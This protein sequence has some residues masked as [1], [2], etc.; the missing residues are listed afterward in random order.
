MHSSVISV[1]HGSLRVQRKP[2]LSKCA[3]WLPCARITKYCVVVAPP[4]P[5]K[6]SFCKRKLLQLWR[7]T[8]NL[9]ILVGLFKKKL[10]IITLFSQYIY[11]LLLYIINNKHIFN[12]NNEIQEYITRS[13][14]NLHV[15][16]L[17]T[18]KFD[19]GAYITYIKV[20]NHLSQSIKILVNDEKS[21]YS[22][23]LEA[24]STPGP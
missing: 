16:I 1:E 14:G 15:P 20:Y 7:R 18:S 17:N 13:D 6:C 9:E 11:S 4:M 10:E 23:L 5:R 21:W 2:A 12:F 3:I 22:F 24:E 19:K 8:L